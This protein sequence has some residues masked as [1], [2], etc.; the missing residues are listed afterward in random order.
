M[1]V[2]VNADGEKLLDAEAVTDTDGKQMA[3]EGVTGVDEDSIK[4]LKEKGK[5][6]RNQLDAAELKKKHPPKGAKH[7]VNLVEEDFRDDVPGVE[8]VKVRCAMSCA[9]G[10]V[11]FKTR[12]AT[13]VLR[14]GC[15]RS[16]KS[17]RRMLKNALVRRTPKIA[18]P[19]ST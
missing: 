13:R 16:W 1:C 8:D 14:R 5:M 3:D 2:F 12:F 6:L 17:G 9:S 4:K 7:N 19:R 11:C 18:T 10:V 15:K